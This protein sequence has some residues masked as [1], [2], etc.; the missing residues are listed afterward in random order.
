[1]VGFDMDKDIHIEG[2]N[3]DRGK[4]GTEDMHIEER[5]NRERG[6]IGTEDMHIEEKK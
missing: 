1:V 5:M 2:K 6:K 3:R 4:I